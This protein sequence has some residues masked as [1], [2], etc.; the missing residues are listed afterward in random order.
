M[1]QSC[2]TGLWDKMDKLH[3]LLD[4]FPEMPICPKSKG[5]DISLAPFQLH[6][7][8]KHRI[9]FL[10][11]FSSPTNSWVVYTLLLIIL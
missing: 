6:H 7:H 5:P 8:T 3:I 10:C 9:Y 11:I 2:G 1:V 4:I